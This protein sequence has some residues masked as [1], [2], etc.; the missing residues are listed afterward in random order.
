MQLICSLYGL[1][2]VL[3][4]LKNTKW[5]NLGNNSVINHVQMSPKCIVRTGLTKVTEFVCTNEGKLNMWMAYQS[6][7]MQSVLKSMS[8]NNRIKVR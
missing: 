3:F 8:D 2:W 1:I 7:N 5:P 6:M 4:N